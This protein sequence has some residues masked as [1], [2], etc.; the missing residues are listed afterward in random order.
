MVRRASDRVYTSADGLIAR[1]GRAAEDPHAMT[2]DATLGRLARICAAIVKEN[3]DLT[4]EQVAKGARLQLR[5][6]MAQLGRKSA[7]ARAA[8]KDSG[9]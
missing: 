2:T 3:P 9:E 7:E 1:A 4:P 6:E 8:R 5:A